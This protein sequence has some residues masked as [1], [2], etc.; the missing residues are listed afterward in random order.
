MSNTYLYALWLQIRINDE[1]NKKQI[2]L[3]YS[4]G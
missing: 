2:I 1:N 3:S 4:V